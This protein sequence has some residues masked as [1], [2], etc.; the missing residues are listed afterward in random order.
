MILVC[1]DAMTDI[2]WTGDVARISPEAPVPVVRVLNEERRAGAADNVI[3]NIRAMGAE[4][5]MATCTTSRKI[6]LVARSQQVARIDFD[7]APTDGNISQ[8]EALYREHLPDCSIVVISDYAKGSLKNV[9]E[10][11]ELA[12]DA[13]KTVLVD[14]KGH[15]YMRYSGADIIKPN[16][17][18][19]REMIG[20]WSDEAQLRERVQVLL[21]TSKIRAMLLTQGAH[22]M[23]LFTDKMLGVHVAA[24]RREVYDV[25][26]AGDTAIAAFAVSLERG[27]DWHDALHFS[28]KAAGIVCGRFGTAIANEEE[29]FGL[30]A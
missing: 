16:T 17:H 18:E 30:S 11:I 24:T 19:L 9:R 23:T 26:G 3:A 7:D 29:V 21:S 6:R 10:L 14:P 2:Y 25:T 5:R 28:N 4:A 15:D 20:G 8:M 12:K 27:L 1:G 13:G 22:G